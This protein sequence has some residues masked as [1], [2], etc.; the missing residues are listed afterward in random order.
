MEE[1]ADGPR[2]F[3]HFRNLDG[4]LRIAEVPN[5]VR[6]PVFSPDRLRR[7]AF[8]GVPMR[9]QGSQ[10]G[11]FCLVAKE[12]GGAF[13]DAD[14]EILVPFGAQA[15]SA[16]ATTRACH[17]ARRARTDLKVLVETSLVGI[18][19]FEATTGK[20]AMLNE[21]QGASRRHFTRRT[22]RPRACS[23]Y[24]PVVSRLKGGP[25]RGQAIR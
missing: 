22:S 18:A 5:H 15:A 11:C 10:V 4:S 14:E 8:L 2:L 23:R 13:A 3:G 12:N 9:D 6:T 20:V 17:D 16:I 19:V 25:R 21:R 24:W 7:G 1:R